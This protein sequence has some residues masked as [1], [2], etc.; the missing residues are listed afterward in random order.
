VLLSSGEFVKFTGT[1]CNEE[2]NLVHDKYAFGTSK[3]NI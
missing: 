3:L 2:C 1:C